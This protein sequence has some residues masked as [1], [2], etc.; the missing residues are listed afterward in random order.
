[1][2][3]TGTIILPSSSFT[4]MG[5]TGF[6]EVA[7]LERVAGPFHIMPLHVSVRS[8]RTGSVV[9]FNRCSTTINADKCAISWTYEG[10]DD[11]GNLITL[12]VFND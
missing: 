4:W 1:M 6:A 9:E 12:I 8:G 3:T 10:L 11:A 7:E 5:A 2:T